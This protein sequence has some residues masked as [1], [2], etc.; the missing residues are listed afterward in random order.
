MIRLGQEV[1]VVLPSYA[2][3][4]IRLAFSSDSYVGFKL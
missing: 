1:C 4:R 3:G 2:V